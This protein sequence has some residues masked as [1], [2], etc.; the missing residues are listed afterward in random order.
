MH[1]PVTSLKGDVGVATDFM[2]M[3]LENKSL[4]VLRLTERWV[5][6]K[7]DGTSVGEAEDQESAVALAR[8]NAHRAG[9]S[10]IAI[11]SEDGEVEKTIAIED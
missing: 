2:S 7:D 6:E 8:E 1:Q 5:V 3:P 9:A 11:H 4:H 10:E